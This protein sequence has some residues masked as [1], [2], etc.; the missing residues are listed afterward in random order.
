M[1]STHVVYC[2]PF[3]KQCNIKVLKLKNSFCW[4]EIVTWMLSNVMWQG[5]IDDIYFSI[6]YHSLF[7]KSS[8]CCLTL[9]TMQKMQL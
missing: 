8:S 7:L 9:A 6:R 1:G 2:E 5:Y 4:K 3:D